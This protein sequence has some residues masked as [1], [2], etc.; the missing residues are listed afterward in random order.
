[1][2]RLLILVTF[3]FLNFSGAQIT[4]K[5]ARY[6]AI[7]PDGTTIAFTYKGNLFRVASAGG[8]A[9]QLTFHK[10]HDYKAIWSNDG[11]R[12]AFASDRYGNFDVF[13]MD[14][15]GGQATRLTFHSNDEVP[16]TFSADDV[17]V[18]FGGLRQDDVKHRQYPNRSQPELYAVAATSGSVDQVLTVPAQDVQISADGTFLLYH[19]KKGYEDEFR[20]HHVSAITRE[21]KIEIRF[22]PK[23]RKVFII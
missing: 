5:W 15:L 10:A 13:I 14:A 7:S 8:T 12:I 16:Y 22:Y 20:K 2:K 11:K 9:T 6:P 18:L 3:L 17:T 19:D 4:P 1:M 21:E 23:I